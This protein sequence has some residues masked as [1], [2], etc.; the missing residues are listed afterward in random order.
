MSGDGKATAS[1]ILQ[2]KRGLVDLID[3]GVAEKFAMDINEDNNITTTDLSI[4][5]KYIVEE[6]K[7]IITEKGIYMDNQ[8][9]VIDLSSKETT[10]KLEA[11]ILPLSATGEITFKSSNES[12]ASVDNSGKITAKKNGD[13]TITAQ[14]R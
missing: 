7:T 10:K 5:K 6:L 14:S 4:M 2:L 11:K 1:D 13:A 12:I 3:I 9:L 8:D